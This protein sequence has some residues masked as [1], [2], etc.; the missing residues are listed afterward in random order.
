MRYVQLRAFHYVCL[1][2]GFSKAADALY[3]TQPAVSDQI[4]KLEE[5]YDTLL[6]LRHGKRVTPT[7]AGM[8]L[9][10]ITH[11]FFDAE[12]QAQAY[13]AKK[14]TIANGT[15]RIVADSAMHLI[16]II[17][18][19]RLRYPE[20]TIQIQSGNSDTVINRLKKY[21][22]DVGVL[23]T[24]V[25]KADYKHLKLNTSPLIAFVGKSHVLAGRRSIKFESL[26]KQPLVLREQGSR[27][28]SSLESNATE[29]GL[30]LTPAIE[31]QGR[32]AVHELVA[33]GS[34]VGIV[35]RAEL[36]QDPRVVPLTISDCKIVMQETLICLPVRAD[37]RVI[38]A[39][40]STAADC[41]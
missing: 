31:A 22:A 7:A 26:L 2:K 11:R 21:E 6:F 28:R 23:G 9:L 8:E 36:A 34:G 41:S 33:E 18:E 39:F 25:S 37:A 27:T 38:A 15:L 40:F 17:N 30:T 20:V 16:D 35:S 5:E 19:F 1:C 29:R 13:L 14:R 10:E 24:D 32:E 12:A 3:L 4:R